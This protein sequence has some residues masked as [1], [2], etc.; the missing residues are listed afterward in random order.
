MIAHCSMLRLHCLK[1]WCWQAALWCDSVKASYFLLLSFSHNIMIE[2]VLQEMPL[3]MYLPFLFPFFCSSLCFPSL[4]LFTLNCTFSH[5]YICS[6]F[7]VI[8]A[9]MFCFFPTLVIFCGRCATTLVAVLRNSSR[10]FVHPRLARELL[11]ILLGKITIRRHLRTLHCSFLWY[12]PLFH[13]VQKFTM[14]E[15]F[16][17]NN[18]ASLQ[19][20]TISSRM[21]KAEQHFPASSRWAGEAFAGWS[22]GIYRSRSRACREHGPTR[23]ILRGVLA[24]NEKNAARNMFYLATQPHGFPERRQITRT[25]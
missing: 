15:F 22:F 23:R 2:T 16:L 24:P 11:R 12:S 20:G 10:A 1:L 4:F 5:C 8:N 18:S 14:K 9:H 3:Q 25:Q 17:A 6:F 19:H 21:A 13:S 7:H